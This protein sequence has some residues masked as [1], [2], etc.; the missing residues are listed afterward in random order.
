MRCTQCRKKIM[1]DYSCK[2]SN[3]FC[4]NCLPYYKHNCTFDYKEDRKN[5][6]T[7]TNPKIIPIK[8]NQI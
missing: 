5:N 1:I 4:L 3:N 8:V 2:C 6:L 7:E